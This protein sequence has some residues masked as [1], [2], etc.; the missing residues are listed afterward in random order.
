MTEY[1]PLDLRLRYHTKRTDLPAD[2]LRDIGEA[3]EE[4]CRLNDKLLNIKNGYEGSCMTCESV[5]I[6]NKELQKKISELSMDK[7]AQHDEEM[8][9]L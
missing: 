1:R 7:L 8:G 9:L 2:V 5:G 6:L 4:I 3:Y